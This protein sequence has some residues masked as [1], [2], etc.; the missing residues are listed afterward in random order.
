MTQVDI[1]AV[2]VEGSAVGGGSSR[3]PMAWSAVFAG[4]VAAT[5]ISLILIMLGWAIG[6]GSVSPWPGSGASA[7]A[8]GVGAAIWLIVVQWL[9]S[10]FGGYLTGRLRTRWDVARDEVFFRDT[11][12]GFLAWAVATVFVFGLV[13]AITAGAASTAATSAATVASGVA[14]GAGSAAGAAIGDEDS[15]YLVDTLFRQ[16]APGTPAPAA[17]DGADVRAET[18]R[19]LAR[20]IGDGEISEA[21][22]TYLTQL[23]AART[24]L[25]EEE[26]TAR[27]NDVIG[28]AE[29]LETEARAAADEARKAAASFSLFMFI[30]LLV[31]AFIAS[32]AAAYGGQARDE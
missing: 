1:G 27:V 2:V 12:H 25:T 23:I 8:F 31:G 28:Q 6:L 13:G 5:A 24:G 22:R 9:A 18:G 3:S 15:G 11:A 17:D 7:A 16:A 20:G 30:S 14:Q 19:I 10:A 4:A 26:A 32:A 21:D 29:A